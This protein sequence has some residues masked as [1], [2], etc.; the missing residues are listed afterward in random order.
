[1]WD[2]GGLNVLIPKRRGE[3]Y[4]AVPYG[5]HAVA[6]LGQIEAEEGIDM[7]GLDGYLE[8]DYRRCS[9]ERDAIV[10]RVMP[11][12]AKHFGFKSWREDTKLFWKILMPDS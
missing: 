2:S 6:A 11:K 7:C 8:L 4:L 3:G 12:L 9:D 10:A 1:M 5:H